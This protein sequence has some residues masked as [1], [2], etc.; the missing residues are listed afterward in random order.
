MRLTAMLTIASLALT[1]CSDNGGNSAPPAENAPVADPAVVDMRD[2]FPPLADLPKTDVTIDLNQLLHFKMP[3]E[4]GYI[5][6]LQFDAIMGFPGSTRVGYKKHRDE[7]TWTVGL[8]AIDGKPFTR[9]SDNMGRV[10]FKD[11]V[12]FTRTGAEPIHVYGAMNLIFS[13]NACF[14]EVIEGFLDRRLPSIRK[15]VRNA[16]ERQTLVSYAQFEQTVQPHVDQ[17]ERDMQFGGEDLPSVAGCGGVA[18]GKK[19]DTLVGTGIVLGFPVNPVRA[20]LVPGLEEPVT[21]SIGQP[22]VVFK[23]AIPGSTRSTAPIQFGN[24]ITGQYSIE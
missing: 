3:S 10:T 7:V 6:T 1:A 16:I 4:T 15:F 11:L 12:R 9:V 13:G 20:A 5:Y 14:R 21:N 8:P 22:N 17:L 24:S 23:I 19:L 18:L 2:R